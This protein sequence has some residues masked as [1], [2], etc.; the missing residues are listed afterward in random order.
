MPRQTIADGAHGVL[1]HTIRNV[2][3]GVT[4][5]TAHRTLFVTYRSRRVLEIA[6]ALQ[7]G[8]GRWVQVRRTTDD[9]RHFGGEC[10][11]HL[12]ARYAGRLAFARR[13]AGEILVPAVREIAFECA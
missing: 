9:L 8:V 12:S 2:A 3:P 10:V 11:E 13:E 6:Q 4:P 5:H 7:R 1:T